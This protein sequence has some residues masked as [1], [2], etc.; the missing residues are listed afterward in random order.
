MLGLDIS[1]LFERQATDDVPAGTLIFGEGQAGDCMYFVQE[2]EVEIWHDGR[3]LAVIHRES[4]FGELAVIDGGPRSATAI[5]RTDC[6]LVGIERRQFEVMVKRLPH[7]GIGVMQLLA[8]R[9][10]STVNAI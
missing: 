4:I 6:R 5:A 3:L 7:F 10:R 9:M 2:G 8:A 1:T